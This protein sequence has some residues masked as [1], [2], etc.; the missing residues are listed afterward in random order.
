MSDQC[1][2]CERRKDS[3]SDYCVFHNTALANLDKAHSAWRKAFG[4]M[5]KM[6]YFTKVEAMPET[7]KAVKDIMRH[8]RE[9]RV[10]A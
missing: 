7:G 10:V 1:P 6:E 5:A 3:G 4:E 9:K 8:L 2:L